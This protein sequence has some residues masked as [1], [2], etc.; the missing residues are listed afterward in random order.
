MCW[1]GSSVCPG[2][3]LGELPRGL[4]CSALSRLSLECTRARVWAEGSR[5]LSHLEWEMQPGT[6]LGRPPC[7]RDWN[8]SLGLLQ[9]QLF[10][11]RHLPR[12]CSASRWPAGPVRQVGGPETAIGLVR[13]RCSGR[14]CDG[15]MRCLPQKD[16]F[17]LCNLTCNCSSQLFC[18]P[19]TNVHLALSSS[20]PSLLLPSL[21]LCPFLRALKSGLPWVK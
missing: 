6:F 16:A 14:Q 13:G 9:G 17:E 19:V 8:S 2:C 7:L 21:A 10:L 18:T 5:A 3:S 11:C 20:S 12:V 15:W 4:N 1:L